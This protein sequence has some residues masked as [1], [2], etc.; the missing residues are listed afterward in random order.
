MDT[1]EVE[2]YMTPED[3]VRSI[4]PDEKQPDGE[5]NAKIMKY[6]RVNIWSKGWLL[7]VKLIFEVL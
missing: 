7:G 2:I 5:L 1:G 6:Y 4:T 3:F